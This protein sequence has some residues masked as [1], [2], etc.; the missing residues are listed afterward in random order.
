MIRLFSMFTGFGGASFSLEKAGIPYECVGYSEIDQAA[1]KCY[2]QNFPN[3]KNYGD[4]KKIVPEELPYF[5]LL[6]AGFPCQDVSISGHRDLS[7]GRTMLVND[8]FRIIAV[9]KPRYILLENVKGLLS[10]EPL[11]TNIKWTIK[12]LGYDLK[13]KL[14]N[15]K[16]YGIPQNRTRI[17]ILGSRDG[18]EPFKPIFPQKEKLVKY[19]KHILEKEVPKTAYFS[20]TREKKLM[21]STSIEELELLNKG[22]SYLQLDTSG[23]GYNSQ[24]D[25]I[26]SINGIMCSLPSVD[27]YN[28]TKIYENGRIRKLTL[29]ECFRLMGFLND[30]IR[31]E[32]ISK[33]K[34]SSL[35]GNGWDI[36]LVSKIMRVFLDDKSIKL[37]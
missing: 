5:N 22:K 14:L 16:D 35:I 34:V 15:S 33:S 23:K 24:N 25:R 19:V 26:Y 9:K 8:I 21:E 29:K 4:C 37:I 10:T 12:K 2:D 7:K 27:A 13:Y 18:F 6:T 28:K 30:E 32:G 17:W 31:Y 1:I 36:N 20:E 3:R 11:W